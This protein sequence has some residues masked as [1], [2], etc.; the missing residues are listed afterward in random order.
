MAGTYSVY[1]KAIE[2]LLNQYDW[3]HLIHQAHI[4]AILDVPSLKEGNRKELRHFHD[5]ALQHYRALKAMNEDSFETL[6]TAILELKMDSTTM[7]D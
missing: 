4:A 1:N 7:R 2:C 6:L 5:I 3:T